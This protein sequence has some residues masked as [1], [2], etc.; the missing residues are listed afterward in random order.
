MMDPVYE[1]SIGPIVSLDENDSRSRKFALNVIAVNIEF[2]ISKRDQ[3]AIE[4]SSDRTLLTKLE[5]VLSGSI[6]RSYIL[7][8][9]I[10]S[11]TGGSRE[12][13]SGPL[14]TSTLILVL[15]ISLLK[16]LYL[17]CR[18]RLEARG[19]SCGL[20]C[21]DEQNLEEIHRKQVIFASLSLAKESFN[22]PSLRS[23]ILLSPIT[24]LIEQAV[25][26]MLREAPSEPRF[27]VDVIDTIHPAYRAMYKKRKAY[28]ST[29][30]SVVYRSFVCGCRPS[31][32][33]HRRRTSADKASRT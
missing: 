19:I 28:Y 25:G 4:D 16:Y 5:N 11:L 20:F 10:L 33:N 23:I 22:I 29:F 32:D 27:V 24:S 1:H 12:R 7:S 31:S 9:L 14:P 6:E 2:P 15:R 30:D 8:E 18:D 3:R 17:M 13:P 21:G 26:R